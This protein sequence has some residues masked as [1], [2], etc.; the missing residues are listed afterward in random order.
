MDKLKKKKEQEAIWFFGERE[1]REGREF[2]FNIFSLRF[3][4]KFMKIG[5]QVFIGT[6]GKF[7]LR[8]DTKILEFRQTLGGREFSYL[9]YF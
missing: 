4:L 2:L 5:S 3:F 9:C 7:D 6:E 1:R 8:V